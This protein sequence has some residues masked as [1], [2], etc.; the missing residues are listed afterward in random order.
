M[1]KILKNKENIYTIFLFIIVLFFA[2][3]GLIS[4]PINKG[5]TQ[6]DSAVFQIM[7][8]GMVEG[9]VIYKDLF[10]H[11]GPIMYVINAIAYLISPQIGLFIVE[12]SLIYIGTLFIFKTSKIFTNEKT[13]F[14]MALFYLMLLF[15]YIWGGNFTEE[16]AMTFVSIALFCIEKIIYEKKHNKTLWIIIGLTF[17]LTIFI[18]PTYIAIWIAFGIAYLI[19]SIKENKIKELITYIMYMLLGTLIV[20]IPILIYLLVNND[21]SD[22]IKS[23]FTM[24]M[25]YSTSTL[26]EKKKAFLLLITYY[27]YLNFC[28]IGIICNLVILVDKNIKYENKIFITSFYVIS[29]ILTCWAP[30]AFQ[31]YLMQLAPT[32]T[33]ELIM[34]LYLISKIQNKDK[35][36]PKKILINSIYIIATIYLILITSLTISKKLG[37]KSDV[38]KE[39]EIIKEKLDKVKS[40]LEKND[41]IIVLGNEPYYYIY[42]E[43][44]PKFKY[45]FQIPIISYDEQIKQ[46]TQNYILNE[47]PKAI[48]KDFTS[49]DEQEFIGLYGNEIENYINKEYQEYGEGRFKYYI[50]K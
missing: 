50:K 15:L 38:A 33:F 27:K 23:F 8:R 35:K 12:V 11:K 19:Y 18:K 30:R 16:Y 4:S 2:L 3:I 22:F 47:K 48:I 31:H 20:A 14:I 45:F 5:I 21:I 28:I 13:S 44:Y 24:N 34:F 49:Y 10:D 42:L 37:V 43:K 7:G 25:Q 26:S 6:N 1:N 41:E 9:Q 32:I 17:A 29:V 46:D 40:Q 36:L 39:S